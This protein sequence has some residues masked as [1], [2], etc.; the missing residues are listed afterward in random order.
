MEREYDVR[1]VSIVDD[2]GSLR[3]SVRNLLTSVGSGSRRS[4]PRRCFSSRFIGRPRLP[5]SRSADARDERPR[6]ARASGSRG[7]TD[8][9]GHCD[10]TR[11]RRARRRA[12]QAGAI[13]FLGKPFNG[14]ALLDAVRRA[15]G[16]GGPVAVEAAAPAGG[17]DMAMAHMTGA[18][19]RLLRMSNRR[20]ARP[21]LAS[22]GGG[23]KTA[24]WRP[25]PS[26]SLRRARS[27]GE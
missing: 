16:G 4:T 11:R 19:D 7:L 2:D 17:K 8:S 22:I 26:R 27:R 23:V 21:G 6:P 14:D 5:G 9:R 12:L 3:R 10:R 13:A 25:V 1:L 24:T 20:I 18:K 15:M